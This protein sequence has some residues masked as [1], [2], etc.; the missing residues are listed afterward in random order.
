MIKSVGS[1]SQFVNISTS[2][3]MSTYYNAN[4]GALGAGNVRFNSSTQSLEVY[5]G[6]SWYTINM[7]HVNIQLSP[8]AEMLL[9]WAKE[10]KLKEDRIADLSKKYPQLK[11]AFDAADKA[12]EQLEILLNLV[13][14]EKNAG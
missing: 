14:S 11:D 5:D 4:S 9:N 3:A 7:A 1:L 13:E 10:Q 6:I 12:T 8:E 2:G